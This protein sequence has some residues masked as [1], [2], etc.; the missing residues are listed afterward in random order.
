MNTQIRI[1]R[2]LLL[3]MATALCGA[4]AV[5]PEYRTPPPDDNVPAQWHARLPHGGEVSALTQWWR[6]FDDPLLA[7]L[8]DA[9]EAR[10]PDIDAAVAAV[11]EARAAVTGSRAGLLPGISGNGV[12]TR[13]S[14]SGDSGGADT[15]PF[16]LFN[17]SLDASWELDLFGGARRGLEASR[18]RLQAA[19]AD[20]HEA[21]VTLAAEV[22][23][24][25]VERRYCERLVALY[26][27]T[28]ESRRETE[29]LTT[30][31]LKAGFVAPADEAQARAGSY[32]SENQLIAQEG[33]CQ[34]DLNRLAQ[35]TALPAAQLEARLAA[36]P[37]RGAQAAGAAAESA[38]RSGIPVPTNPAV[39][40]VPAALLSQRPDL[41][42]AER[43]LAA[44][45]ANIGVAV[46]SRLPSLSLGGSI[47]INHLAHSGQDVRSWSW[48]PQLTLPIFEGGAGVARVETA[49]AQY[50]QALAGYRGKVLV[51]VQEVEDALTRVDA[52][53][54]RADAA[55]QAERNYSLLLASQ[56]N[57]YRLGATSLLDL[58]DTRRLTLASR[59]SLAAVEL[60]ISQSWI[61]LYKAAGGG[62][63]DDAGTAV[64][65][66]SSPSGGAAAAQNPA[67]AG[68]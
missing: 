34:Q 5:G 37:D 47:G 8:V 10:H 29:R 31:K 16:T 28:L 38:D 66:A 12:M 13:S 15:P 43:T 1:G 67:G 3:A 59:E 45:S 55:R 35:L 61:A 14:G 56:E 65:Q 26:R 4:C 42:S 49:R 30:L 7:E 41:M 25:Y 40:A 6:Q 48:S 21:R 19:E 53:V 11:R 68:A 23:D 20:W 39:P 9:A 44:A 60:E 51:A 54:R 2:R 52:S 46:A 17:G 22:A 62:W 36:T 24:A 63:R 58:E 57:R 33:V 50:D 27:D 18:A 64:G 32:E